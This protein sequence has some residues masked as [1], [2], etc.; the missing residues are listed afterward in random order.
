MAEKVMEK[1][2][3][4]ALAFIIAPL[5]LMPLKVGYSVFMNHKLY[6]QTL[7]FIPIE[8]KTTRVDLY[9][10]GRYSETKYLDLKDQ[11]TIK[12]MISELEYGGYYVIDSFWPFFKNSL[13]ESVSKEE[14]FYQ[15]YLAL[16]DNGAYIH[17]QEDIC[18]DN[19][20][21]LKYPLK[22]DNFETLYLYCESL[23]AAGQSN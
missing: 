6:E 8:G 13:S 22:Y 5:L 10:Q 11:E 4:F 3:S 18:F 21:S 23:F 2:K 1:I 15:I 7:A 17:V 14:T 19:S 12:V 9:Q 16:E 20:K